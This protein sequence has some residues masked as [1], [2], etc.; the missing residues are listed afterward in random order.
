MRLTNG[1]EEEKPP[2]KL[3]WKQTGQGNSVALHPGPS[4]GKGAVVIKD[5]SDILVARMCDCPSTPG[6]HLRACTLGP[7]PTEGAHL[8]RKGHFE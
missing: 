4:G 7:L 5:G 1:L 6:L 2:P 8:S 3:S